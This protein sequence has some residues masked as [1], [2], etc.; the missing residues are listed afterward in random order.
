MTIPFKAWPWVGNARGA[1]GFTLFAIFI[2]LVS[3]L[4]PL[5]EALKLPHWSIPTAIHIAGHLGTA[6]FF[7]TLAYWGMV[8]RVGK[9]LLSMEAVRI[10]ATNWAEKS[11]CGN[12]DCGDD[13]FIG[14]LQS[15]TSR[16]RRVAALGGSFT[17]LVVV[18]L[19]KDEGGSLLG[20][21]L[22]LAYLIPGVYCVRLW[23]SLGALTPWD[24]PRTARSLADLLLPYKRAEALIGDLEERFP[25]QC[26]E[27]GVVRARCWYW[28]Q[29]MYSVLPVVWAVWETIR[30]IR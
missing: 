22:A 11:K 3:L 21:I 10:L 27:I 14:F 8:S 6:G 9:V 1:V 29:V 18:A 26:K 2:G 20:A 17:L 5:R 30:R 19:F 4:Q 28:R 25:R 23:W 15:N 16:L 7:L 13:P 12:V 24:T